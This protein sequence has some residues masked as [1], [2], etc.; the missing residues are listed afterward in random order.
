MS[1]M[2]GSITSQEFE[3]LIKN[4]TEKYK[5]SLIVTYC[6]IGFR[7]GKYGTNLM[8]AGFENVRNGEGIVLSTY[9][10]EN[11][12]ISKEGVEVPS[13][14]VHTFG[15][16]W[17]LASDKYETVQFGMLNYIKKGIAALL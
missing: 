13:N 11:L 5:K 15:C 2:P 14:I 16:D 1:V 9:V 3:I 12:V 17:D 8:K 7:S 10:L 4:D 6:T